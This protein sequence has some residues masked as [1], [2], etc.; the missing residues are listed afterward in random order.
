[1]PPL[2]Q[3][4]VALEIPDSLAALIGKIIINWTV[5]ETNLFDYTYQLIG[6]TTKQGRLSVKEPAVQ[7]HV[8]LIEELCEL[9]GVPFPDALATRRAE[10]QE[11]QS[12]RNW[13]AHGL[14]MRHPTSNLAHIRILRGQWRP[15]GDKTSR[16]IHPEARLL[17]VTQLGQILTDIQSAIAMMHKLRKELPDPLPPSR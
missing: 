9:R 14:I 7:D 4:D 16:K 17:T 3:W 13:L 5:F 8:S 1:M 2:G 6:I 15:A 12:W 10:L 11:L